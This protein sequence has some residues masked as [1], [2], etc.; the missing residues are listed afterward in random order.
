MKKIQTFEQFCVNEMMMIG[1]IPTNPKTG[2]TI[3]ILGGIDEMNK[4]MSN[5]LGSS[6]KQATDKLDKAIDQLLT[7]VDGEKLLDAAEDYFGM[8]A[9]KLTYS[10]V[11]SKLS[12]INEL[13]K[14]RDYDDVRETDGESILGPLSEV[15][16]GVVQKILKLV[17]EIFELNV[18]TFG[19]M[20]TIVTWLVDKCVV[21]T[22]VVN[23][24]ISIVLSLIAWLVI[25][26][27][28]KIIGMYS[29]K[30]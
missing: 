17:A 27:L 22:Y 3:D 29:P 9:N 30:P 16:D 24:A 2:K 18:N 25:S 23:P 8:S 11:K 10:I 1:G 4:E 20:G 12:Q 13:T 19:L 14:Y 15:K 26:I 5:L 7:E 6:F 21:D 28:R